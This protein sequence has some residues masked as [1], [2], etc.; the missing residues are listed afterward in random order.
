MTIDD[1][2]QRG[3]KPLVDECWDHDVLEDGLYTLYIP[4]LLRKFRLLKIGL[5]DISSYIHI[6]YDIECIL[7]RSLALKW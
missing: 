2:Y 1:F 6:M 7:I 4:R 3:K 5:K